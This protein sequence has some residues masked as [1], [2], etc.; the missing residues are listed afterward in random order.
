MSEDLARLDATAQAELVRNGEASPLELVDAAIER[1]EASNGEI[2]AVIHKLYDGR[3]RRLRAS[4]PT[5]RS[6]AFHSC[7]RTSARR[8]PASRSTW[9]CSCSRTRDFRSPVDTYLASASRRPASSPRQDQHPGA[10]DPADDRAEGLRAD[11]Q[12]V[13]PLRAR[14]RIERWIGG[15]GRRGHGPGRPR[16]RRRRLDPHPGGECGL[17]GSSR[18]RRASRRARHRRQHVRPHGRAG[19]VEVGP[20]HGRDPRGGPRAGAG[21]SVR[22]PAARRGRTRDEVGADPG[23][24]R[25]G[26]LDRAAPGGRAERGRHRGRR[27]TAARLLESLGHDVEECFPT[28]FEDFD[29]IR[30]F[31]TRW[32][33]GQAATLDHWI[34]ARP[35]DR[36]G[37][38]R[39]AHLGAGRRGQ[40]PDRGAI[41]HRRRPAPACLAHGRRLVRVR[42]RPAADADAG[43][44]AAAARQL[45]RL[46]PTIRSRRYCGAR[47]R[48]PSRPTST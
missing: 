37:R 9:A 44:A 45:R 12:P 33:A 3:V 22:R 40:A 23:K 26:L 20:R 25:I 1:I 21:R 8:S 36:P 31:L 10:R 24:L 14:R 11:P 35:G 43:R 32:M 2:N 7:S 38:R 18:P 13:G 30:L 17:S 46:G 39:A 41:H 34:V 47:R 42:L 48:R 29:L 6:R 27:A 4:C 5:A 15:R 19:G 28:G 16:Q